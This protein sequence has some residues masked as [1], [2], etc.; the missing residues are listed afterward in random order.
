MDTNQFEN[1]VKALN[2]M[3]I[4]NQPCHCCPSGKLCVVGKSEIKY[5]P[6]PPLSGYNALGYGKNTMEIIIATCNKCGHVSQYKLATLCDCP[7]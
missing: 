5:S 4:L 1:A 2:K 6:Q 3:K 7:Q